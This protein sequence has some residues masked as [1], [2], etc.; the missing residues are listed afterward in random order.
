MVG[1]IGLAA[2]GLVPAAAAADQPL[3]ANINH[4]VARWT[5]GQMPVA[6]LCRTV[7]QVGF[8]AID[9]VGP[10][11]WP[12]PKSHG[13]RSPMGNGAELGPEKGVGRTRLQDGPA[14]R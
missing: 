4:S 13:V 7:K 12:T 8:S 5:F 9:L 10:D 3:K 11:D 2:S 1:G 14:A 6:E